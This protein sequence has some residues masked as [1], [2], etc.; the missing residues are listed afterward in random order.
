VQK[1]IRKKRTEAILSHGKALKRSREKRAIALQET[2]E[3]HQGIRRK[4]R[5]EEGIGLKKQVDQEE[6]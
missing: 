3:K 6:V 4:K 2:V 5:A 1:S